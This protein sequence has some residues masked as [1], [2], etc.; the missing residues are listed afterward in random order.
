M[1]VKIVK[2]NVE[3]R[4]RFIHAMY[5]GF[6][7]GT[8]SQEEHG[9]LKYIEVRNGEMWRVRFGMKDELVAGGDIQEAEGYVQDGIWLEYFEKVVMETT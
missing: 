2:L 9:Y 5:D 7:P 3:V 6:H 4:R 1:A 8:E